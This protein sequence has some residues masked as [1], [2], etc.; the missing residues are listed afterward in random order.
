MKTKLSVLL[1]VQGNFGEV[2]RGRLISENTSVAVKTCREN[3]APE[4]KSKFLMEA[5]SVH[6]PPHTHT[7]AHTHHV[8]NLLMRSAGS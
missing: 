6:K 7:G 4:H 3:L 8:Q 2:Y 1:A 5:R